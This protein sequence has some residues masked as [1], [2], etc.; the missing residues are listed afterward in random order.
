MDYLEWVQMGQERGWI[1]PLVC[2]THDG[3]PSSAA[4]DA[5]WEDGIDPCQ[6]IFRRYDDPSHKEEVEENHA[7][8]QWRQ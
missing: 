3:V 5:M 6:W 8:S 2:A 7:P 1:G 4:E